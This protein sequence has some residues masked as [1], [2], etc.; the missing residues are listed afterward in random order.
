VDYYQRYGFEVFTVVKMW[1]VV[2][3][4]TPSSFLG[5]YKRFRRP[6]RFCLQ[7]NERISYFS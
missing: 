1:A 3:D 2:W 7:G 5:A 6:Y 4:M